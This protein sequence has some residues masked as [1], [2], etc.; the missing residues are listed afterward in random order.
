M[1]TLI[2]PVA[3]EQNFLPYLQAFL[4]FL[5]PALKAYDDPQLCSV[6]VGLIGDICRALGELS[7]GYCDMFMSALLENLTSPVLDRNVKISVVSCFGDIALAIGPSFGPYLGAT[8][9]VLRQVGDQK[10]DPVCLK[11]LSS[12]VS[13]NYLRRRT[14]K[15]SITIPSFARPFS[16]P[17]LALSP[18]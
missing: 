13:S 8:M 14:T 5:A 9:T 16:R 12:G 1:V 15:R 4:P 6:A 10:V 18:G 11:W 7:A 17:I 2:N 3:L